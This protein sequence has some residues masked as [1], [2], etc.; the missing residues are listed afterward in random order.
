VVLAGS[1]GGFLRQGEYVKADGGDYDPNN[2]QLLNTIGTAVGLTN[3]DGGPLDD[4]G[5][6]SIVPRGLLDAIQA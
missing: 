5:D 6:L 3:A 1:A 4:F 2:S